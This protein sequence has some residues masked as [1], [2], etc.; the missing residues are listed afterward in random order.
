MQ[1]TSPSDRPPTGYRDVLLLVRLHGDPLAVIHLEQG[2]SHLE[3]FDL[4]ELIWSRLEAEIRSHVEGH[5]C[6]PPP[7]AASSLMT[8]L[9]DGSCLE[10]ANC[11]PDGKVAVI[12]P[13]TGRSEQLS[14]CLR[15]VLRLDRRAMEVIVVDNRPS[16]S[17][18]RHLVEQL[19][20]DDSRVKYLAEPRPGS[21]IARNRAIADTDADVVAFT[22]DDVVV[23][24]GWLDWLL[25][26]FANPC[27]TTVTG[28]VLPLELDTP[29][30]KQF[31][32]YA[33]FSRGVT[34]R[35]YDI[36]HS[37]A[38]ERLLYP[39]WGGMFGSGN[40]VAFRRDAL[41][42]AGECDPRLGPGSLA[43]GGEDM[44]AMSRAILRGGTLVY[45]PRGVV[46]HEHRRD[47]QALRRQLFSY[48]VGLTAMLTKALATDPRFLVALAKSLPIALRLHSKHRA[49][50]PE[51]AAARLPKELSR[52]ERRGMVL[53]P[54]RYLRS[55]LRARRL[56]A[57]AASAGNRGL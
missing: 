15:S 24:A 43:L 13:T 44:D 23:D 31:E 57:R 6:M 46:W 56:R 19:A 20:G 28:M 37:R 48:G 52:I 30:Q 18:T 39:Y 11:G 55:A 14:R 45:E 8:G 12:I 17:D 38:D 25:A 36:E 1:P 29:A 2:F 5:A 7:T 47:D 40:N 42:A 21:S 4:A 9:T 32:Q 34:S 35:T 27:V 54:F 50:P 53:G 16:V 3:P 49:A 26:P 51:I 33:G 41:V 22:D 10:A